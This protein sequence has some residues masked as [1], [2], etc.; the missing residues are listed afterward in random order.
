MSAAKAWP[1]IVWMF[2]TDYNTNAT[3]ATKNFSHPTLN[4][5]N[6]FFGKSVEKKSCIWIENWLF[7]KTQRN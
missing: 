7:M 2:T 6:F 1:F 5:V 3:I 4:L